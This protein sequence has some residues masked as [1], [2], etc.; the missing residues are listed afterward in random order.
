MDLQ[1][2]DTS[3]ELSSDDNYKSN[4]NKHI[5]RDMNRRVTKLLSVRKVNYL[6]L[7]L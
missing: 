4:Q 6:L 5:S 2:D 3:E 1:I 7:L